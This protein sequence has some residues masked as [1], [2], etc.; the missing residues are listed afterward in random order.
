MLR[1]CK[2]E[3]VKVCACALCVVVVRSSL[4]PL[5]PSPHDYHK[6]QFPTRLAHECSSCTNAK[7]WRT[8]RRRSLC[9][10]RSRL[11]PPRRRRRQRRHCAICILCTRVRKARRFHHST[12]GMPANRVG[13]DVHRAISEPRN[14][15]LAPLSSLSSPSRTK[16]P[17][18]IMGEACA[19]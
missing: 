7:P 2:C 15:D 9:E 17:R 4:L 12:K 11:M 3:S 1:L 10:C 14:D 18:D 16:K 19:R 8:W 13:P 5:L 6:S